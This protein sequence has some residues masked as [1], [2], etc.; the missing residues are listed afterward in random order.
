MNDQ[1]DLAKIFAEAGAKLQQGLQQ[2]GNT[3]TVQ[4]AMGWAYRGDLEKLA[5]ALRG[6][7]TEQ[8]REVSA[9]AAL[10]ASTADEELAG[11]D[12]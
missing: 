9:A 4:G 11:R 10:L 8:L 2:A 12:G 3:L 7:S 6:M 5:A 1:P